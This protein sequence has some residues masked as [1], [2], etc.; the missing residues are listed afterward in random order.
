VGGGVVA[1]E[2]GIDGVLELSPLLEVGLDPVLVEEA[3]EEDV[4]GGDAG[5]LHGR[6]G[7]HPQLVAGRADHVGRGD[8]AGRIEALAVDDHLLAGRAEALQGQAQLVG[9]AGLHAG[10]RQADKQ[11]LD[12]A[13]ALGLAQGFDHRHHRERA[14]PEARQRIG[15]ILVGQRLAQVELEHGAL[16]HRRR[17]GGAGRYAHENEGH[18]HHED[19]QTGENAGHGDE[20]LLHLGSRHDMLRRTL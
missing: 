18:A 3:L 12:P 16:G 10:F 19:H 1:V 7:L 20:E 2:V 17:A 15:R 14:P 11:R 6:A 5:H 9:G 8:H 13:V 4:L